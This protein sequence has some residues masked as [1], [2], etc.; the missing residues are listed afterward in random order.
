MSRPL[1]TP[2]SQDES[3]LEPTTRPALPRPVTSLPS[4][5]A[6]VSNW[7][8][9]TVI[10]AAVLALIATYLLL[11]FAGHWSGMRAEWPLLI[12]LVGGVPLLFELL[13]KMLRLEFGADLIAGVSVVTAV[14]MHEYLVAS[15]VILMLSGGQALESYATRRASSVLRALAKR[16]PTEAHRVIEPSAGGA[17]HQDVAAIDISPGDLLLVLPHEICPVDGEVV[18]GYG[19][20]DESFLTGEPFELAKAPGA[21]VISGAV[22]GAAMLKIR[23]TKPAVESR[24]AR[25]LRVI[26]QTEQ[27]QPHLRRVADRLGAWYTP[28]ALVL[29]ALGWWISGT[30]ER[31]LAVAVIATPCP[32]LLAIPVAIM[33]GIS[34]AARRGIVVRNATVLEQIDACRTFIFDK[35][36]TLT[37]G[38]PVLTEIILGDDVREDRVIGRS[39]DRVIGKSERREGGTSLDRDIGTSGHREIGKPG[40]SAAATD[41]TSDH[42]TTG[43]PDHP[44]FDS[45][46]SEDSLLSLAASLETYSRHPLARGILKVAKQ[47]GIAMHVPGNVTEH[48][49]DGLRGLV[50]GR[51]VHITG[52][53]MALKIYGEIPGLPPATSGLECLVFVDDRFAGLIKFQ[54]EAKAESMPFIGHLSPKHRAQ[55]VILLSGDKEA[56]VRRMAEEVG[57]QE[58]YFGKS[59]EEK[60]EFV[61][62]Q[63]REERTLFVGDGIND[64]PSMLAATVGV[65]LGGSSDAISESADAVVLDSSLRKID[66]LIHIGRRMKTIAMQSAVGG[67]ALSTLGMLAAASGYLPPL[68]GAIA[69]EVIDLLAVL[70]A[71]RVAVGKK[72]MADF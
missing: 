4:N 15:I 34:Q 53:K 46:I 55:R 5:P 36:G 60:L 70:N 21:P 26:Q 44:I 1:T 38:K 10:A 50:K 64:A 51:S 40:G 19:R 61:R 17:G 32:L 11:R 29:A 24:Y 37:Y 30:P 12:A 23:A 42:P 45:P 41:Q 20:M 63:T 9:D 13:R 22:N 49:G 59:P 56:E 39:G 72:D 16:M 54:D 52:R 33:G 47:R 69:Q 25:I 2:A 58:V 57:I 62:E 31:F 3:R 28:L 35:T 14:L 68:E 71:L 65:A 43:S 6:D 27:T 8:R 48:P 18:E 66:E 7:L 67:M